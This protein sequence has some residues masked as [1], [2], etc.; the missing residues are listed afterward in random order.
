[1]SERIEDIIA[2]RR[3]KLESL[4]EAGIDP[5]PSETA[6]DTTTIEALNNFES[7]A[8]SQKT[9]TVSGRIRSIRVQ[10]KVGFMHIEDPSGRLQ[11]FFK[12]DA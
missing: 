6:R 1:M 8:E 12:A 5:Y 2:F 7:L 3:K 9:V 11:L 10:G 4:K